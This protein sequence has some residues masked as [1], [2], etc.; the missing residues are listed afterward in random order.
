MRSGFE[1]PEVDSAMNEWCKDIN[2]LAKKKGLWLHAANLSFVFAFAS[3]LGILGRFAI[4][5]AGHHAALEAATRALAEVSSF[6]RILP[7]GT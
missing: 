6:A 4:T 5:H 2:S 7:F 1:E 3:T